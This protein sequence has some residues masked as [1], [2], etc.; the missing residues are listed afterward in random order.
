MKGSVLDKESHI[1]S[2]NDISGRLIYSK[3]IQKNKEE[4]FNLEDQLENGN[5]LLTVKSEKGKLVKSFKLII[6][7]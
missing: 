3:M 5:Y 6:K 2:I 7:K 1:V 4:H